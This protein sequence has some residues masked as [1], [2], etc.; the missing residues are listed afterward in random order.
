[1]SQNPFYQP[2]ASREEYVTESALDALRVIMEYANGK[3]PQLQPTDM[4][5]DLR[6]HEI[7]KVGIAANMLTRIANTMAGRKAAS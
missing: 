7:K 3:M 5:T 2:P 6:P 4:F 1:M